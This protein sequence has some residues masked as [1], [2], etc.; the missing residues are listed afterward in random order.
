VLKDF[1]TLGIRGA[2]RRRSQLLGGLYQQGGTCY[3]QTVMALYSAH[4]DGRFKPSQ[5]KVLL[6]GCVSTENSSLIKGTTRW[7]CRGEHS[8]YHHGSITSGTIVAQNFCGSNNVN[9]LTRHLV[10]SERATWGGRTPLHHTL[11]WKLS[12]E[13]FFRGRR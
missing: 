9:L 11:S 5:R 1:C 6:F 2:G 7:V 3:S 13:P 10:S 4:D 8:A 12:P